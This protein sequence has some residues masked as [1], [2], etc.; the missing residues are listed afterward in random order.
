MCKVSICVQPG[1][2]FLFSSA[3]SQ[4]CAPRLSK[5]RPARACQDK[6]SRCLLPMPLQWLEDGAKVQVLLLVP[7]LLLWNC[8]SQGRDCWWWTLAWV[9]KLCGGVTGKEQEDGDALGSWICRVRKKRGL[10]EACLIWVVLLL[11]VKLTEF[12]CKTRIIW[13]ERKLESMGVSYH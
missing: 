1:E 4:P 13:V 12:M 7:S 6:K 11:I 8:K 5:G 9:E 3:S 2:G 10:G